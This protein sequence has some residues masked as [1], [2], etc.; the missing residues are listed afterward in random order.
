MEWIQNME[1]IQ[2]VF[3]ILVFAASAI[4][5]YFLINIKTKS[6]RILSILLFISLIAYG[7][8]SLLESF[9]MINY[10]ILA[11]LCFIISAIGV[12]VAYFFLQLRSSH[13]LIGGIFGVA[14]MTS[15]GVWMSGEFLEATLFVV[16][17]E[18]H[19]TIDLISSGVMGGFSIF[20]I[21]RFLWLR[22]MMII[23]SKV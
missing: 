16:G 15:F 8:H 4:P 2:P 20:I 3:L 6:Q 23:E 11:K 5:L 10:N 9:E 22:R 12:I 18:Q 14:M 1:F 17:G 19:E 13:I 21:V 7:I